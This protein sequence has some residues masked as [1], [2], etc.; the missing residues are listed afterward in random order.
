MQDMY[1]NAYE[2]LFDQHILTLYQ[3]VDQE[4][5]RNWDIRILLE[6]HY[7]LLKNLEREEDEDYTN[8]LERTFEENIK[9]NESENGDNEENGSENKLPE[10]PTDD[11]QE[12]YALRD[13]VKHLIDEVDGETVRYG[14]LVLENETLEKDVTALEA[15]IVRNNESLKIAGERIRE[16][17]EEKA[18][19][20]RENTILKVRLLNQGISLTNLLNKEHTT[21]T[22]SKAEDVSGAKKTA[23]E[24]LQDIARKSGGKEPK[25]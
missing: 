1:K 5:D 9:E 11:Q 24:Q 20:T 8:Y 3:K 13:R 16:L 2:I 10:Y 7:E 23:M 12:L 14:E 4:V 17:V 25:V 22:E 21:P 15:E 18:E 19:L 6:K